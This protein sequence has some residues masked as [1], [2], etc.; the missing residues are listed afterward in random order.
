MSYG[1]DKWQPWVL[2]EGDSLPLLEYAYKCGINTWDTVRLF[3]SPLSSLTT[4]GTHFLT[5]FHH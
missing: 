4:R 1:S 3:P 2:N 5:N